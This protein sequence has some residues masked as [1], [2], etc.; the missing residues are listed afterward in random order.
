MAGTDL[1]GAL[2]WR[3][4]MQGARLEDTV[5]SDADLWLA[6][7]SEADFES[8]S[9]VGANLTEA[10]LST[11]MADLDH[12][13]QLRNVDFRRADLLAANLTGTK[14]IGVRFDGAHLR[15][16]NLTGAILSSDDEYKVNGLTQEQVDQVRWEGLN[17]PNFDG[18]LDVNTGKAIDALEGPYCGPTFSEY[19]R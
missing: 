18:T 15:M 5:L 12:Y 13:I 11:E 10:N 14:C 2:M 16:T 8:T 1:S 17:V 6:D 19:Y 9:F 4:N 7:I 3:T